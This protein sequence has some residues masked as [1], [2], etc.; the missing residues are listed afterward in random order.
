MN[1]KFPKSKYPKHLFSKTSLQRRLA[2]ET[3]NYADDLFQVVEMERL[4]LKKAEGNG[5]RAWK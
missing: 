3:V 4:L 1:L 2:Y 5:R